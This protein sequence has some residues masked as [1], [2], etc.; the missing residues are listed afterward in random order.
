MH[1]IREEYNKSLNRI[2][3]EKEDSQTEEDKKKLRLRR[4]TSLNSLVDYSNMKLILAPKASQ[5][6][7]INEDY[8]D[9][10]ES[11]SSSSNINSIINMRASVQT[12]PND[13]S[14]SKDNILTSIEELLNELESISEVIKDQ[15]VDHIN[16]NDVILTANHSDQLVDFF[17]EASQKKSFHVII[18]ESAPS[19]K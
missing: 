7:N 3:P 10:E 4:I 15:A 2:I 9:E 5:M 11:Y 8:E 16:D 14:E 12:N 13:N 6:S 1:I 17:I 18:A 19:L